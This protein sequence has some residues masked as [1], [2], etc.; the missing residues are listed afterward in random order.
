MV[1]GMLTVSY[2][3]PPCITYKHHWVEYIRIQNIK[4]FYTLPSAAS[5]PRKHTTNHDIIAHL[6]PASHAN[7]SARGGGGIHLLLL[8]LLLLPF[9]FFGGCL[10]LATYIISVAEIDIHT[11]LCSGPTSLPPFHEKA[12]LRAH[13]AIRCLAPPI[14]DLFTVRSVM[15]RK[16]ISKRRKTISLGYIGSSIPCCSTSMLLR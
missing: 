2:K 15:P 4:D 12:P 6:E 5:R 7:L 16:K 13:K 3:P 14:I 1:V 8:L 9:P 10:S 11:Q